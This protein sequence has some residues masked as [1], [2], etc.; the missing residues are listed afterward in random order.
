MAS[1]RERRELDAAIRRVVQRNACIGCGL[2]TRLDTSL[3]MELEPDGFL[4]PHRTDV[5]GVV[6]DDAARRFEQACPGC[7]VAAVRPR[8]SRR[9]PT[10]GS[11]FGVW[12]AWATDD[13]VR[14]RGSSGGA[15]TAL[16]AWLL[17]SG[18]SSGIGSNDAKEET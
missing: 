4:R 14:W 17:D 3:R 11:W 15:L 2:C 9:H 6:A 1:E 18:R 10:M 13:A 12:E 7:R 5:G 8:G 16:H